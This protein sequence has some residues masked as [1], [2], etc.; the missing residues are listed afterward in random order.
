LVVKEVPVMVAEAHHIHF[1]LD[2]HFVLP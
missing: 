2:V 1:L